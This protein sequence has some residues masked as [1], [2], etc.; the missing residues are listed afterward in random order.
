MKFILLPVQFEIKL[1]FPIYPN[2]IPYPILLSFFLNEKDSCSIRL[3]MA[4]SSYAHNYDRFQKAVILP[5][6]KS[7]NCNK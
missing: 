7:D 6:V 5:P 3:V 2:P 1:V 4:C